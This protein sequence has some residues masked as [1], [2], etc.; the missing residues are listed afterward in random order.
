[1][2]ALLGTLVLAL[3]GASSGCGGGGTVCTT[4]YAFGLSIT[5]RRAADGAPVYDATVTIVDGAYRETAMALFERRDA[6]G[7]G[8][9]TWVG[10]GERAGQY[11]ITVS[12]P[13][14]AAVTRQAT[15]TRDECH[16]RGVPIAVS[17]S[18]G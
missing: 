14:Y 5:V 15:V 18:P 6:G 8:E 1:M 4:S 10:A 9:P 2:R 17:L 11:T 7:V 3:V 13:G 12:A 16:V